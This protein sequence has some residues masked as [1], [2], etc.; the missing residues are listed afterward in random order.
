M[1]S[2]M[3][4][5]GCMADFRHTALSP[6]KLESPQKLGDLP[7]RGNNENDRDSDGFGFDNEL[8]VEPRQLAG[9]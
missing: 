3:R 8:C 1:S 6:Q 9:V 7:K 4:R 5:V 2:V